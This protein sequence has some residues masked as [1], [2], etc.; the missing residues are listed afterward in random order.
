MRWKCQRC[1]STFSSVCSLET[2]DSTLVFLDILFY[3]FSVM[4]AALNQQL[5]PILER[6]TGLR[7]ERRLAI[8]F[9]IAG[10]I[11]FAIL[12]GCVLAEFWSLPVVL[13]IAGAIALGALRVRTHRPS[14]SVQLH[15]VARSI[16]ADHPELQALLVTAVQESERDGELNYLQQRVISEAVEEAVAHRWANRRTHDAWRYARFWRQAASG[17]LLALLLI[18]LGASLTRSTANIDG[19]DTPQ[20]N[21]LLS[22][23]GELIFEVLPGDREAERGSRIVITVRFPRRQPGEATLVTQT[24]SGQTRTPMQKNLAD[25]VFGSVIDELRESTEYWIEAV[26]SQ[27]PHYTLTAYDLP[28]IESVDAL[29]LPP[30]SSRLPEEEMKNTRRVSLLEGSELVLTL[31]ANKPIAAG[32]LESKNGEARNLQTHPDRPEKLTLRFRPD[33]D[34][35]LRLHLWDEAGRANPGRE[36]FAI[37]LR[38]N[39]PPKVEIAFPK[40]DAS[41]TPIQELLAEAKVWDDAG[42]RAAGAVTVFEGEEVEIPLDVSK[43]QPDKKQTISTLLDF[44]ALEAEPNQ[45]LT[46][47]FWAED[48]DG[49]GKPRRVESDMFFCEVRHFEEIFTEAAPPPPGEGE[50]EEKEKQQMK[51]LGDML[52]GQKEVINATWSVLRQVRRGATPETQWV[53]DSQLIAQSQQQVMENT[54]GLLEKITDP[55][56]VKSIEAATADMRAAIDSLSV[57]STNT[58]EAPIELALSSERSA[59]NHLL[60]LRQRFFQIM[61]A[62]QQASKSQNSQQQQKQKQMMQMKLKQEEKR[63][64]TQRFAN[65]QEKEQRAQEQKEDLQILNR[66]KELARR[67]EGVA[68]AIRELEAAL[69]AAETEAEKKELLRQLKR[70]QEEQQELL[71]DVDELQERMDAPENRERNTEQR[72]QLAVTR[73]Q[74]REAVEKL[75]DGELQ[76][77]ANAGTRAQRELEE[78]VEDVRER[79]SS[80]FAEKMREL[81]QQAR[82]LEEKQEDLAGKIKQPNQ[83]ERGTVEYNLEN[84]MLSQEAAEQEERLDDLLGELEELSEQTEES[85]PILSRKVYDAIRETELGG[86]R[87]AMKRTQQMLRWNQRSSAQRSEQE[88]RE[89][90]QELKENIE[91][92]AESILGDES[93]ALRMAREQLAQ[94]IDD[95]EVEQ[96]TRTGE[97]TTEENTTEVATG[98]EVAA[99]DG[100]RAE[101]EPGA[102]ANPAG[103]ADATQST[104]SQA[105][106]DKNPLGERGDTLSEEP[107]GKATAASKPGESPGENSE[108]VEHPEDPVETP[109]GSSGSG[110][111]EPQAAKDQDGPPGSSEQP[112]KADSPPNSGESEPANP[113]SQTGE[114]GS[115]Q[116]AEQPGQAGKPSGRPEGEPGQSRTEQANQA[117]GRGSPQAATPDA[118]THSNGQSGRQANKPPAKPGESA[119]QSGKPGEQPQPSSEPGKQRGQAAGQ[120]GTRFQSAADAEPH[121]Q[122]VP[123]APMPLSPQ[124]S[125]NFFE[126]WGPGGGPSELQAPLT[127]DDYKNW[128]D[129]LRDVE[130]MLTDPG[131]QQKAARIRDRA[132]E[133][134]REFKRHSKEPQWD[135]VQETILDPMRELQQQIDEELAK[136]HEDEPLIPLDRD[137]VPERFKELVREYY[138]TL[139]A[140]K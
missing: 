24:E 124:N 27:S 18:L 57:V 16:E 51:E 125:G 4:H 77:A 50:P 126:T 117:G 17:T 38:K 53:E 7:R 1:D 10:F 44:E 112:G 131:L 88:A 12:V 37:R 30:E 32:R 89:G 96:V 135:L 73:E 84:S 56:M 80:E 64:E 59:Y 60:K 23:P 95:V 91:A 90:V 127:G 70:L 74:T 20:A 113:A 122:P 110:A 71:A 101:D 108:S 87:E 69:E 11:V 35:V 2:I 45:L 28:R 129:R 19:L 98:H 85:E 111:S 75:Q 54:Q 100:S 139:G 104:E 65:E 137:P 8:Y 78:L 43:L 31:T 94:L 79:T 116:A 58:L 61:K 36:E 114:P 103:Q 140:G 83:S 29:I 106:K 47:Y 132:R 55:Q 136:L 46:W 21:L 128:S 3:A 33:S 115:T 9:S 62:Q 105:G 120:P 66:L 25:P 92:A 97:N 81:R 102:D 76:E 134:R 130:E 93:E 68:D 119:N 109:A 107:S 49:K 26:G 118:Q 42:L 14:T 82:D 40:K 39:L 63:Y 72:E 123:K 22:D 138:K 99:A 86:T 48:T 67:Q 13:L 52:D 133:V 15:D 121:V 41:V 5:Q 34:D 6:E